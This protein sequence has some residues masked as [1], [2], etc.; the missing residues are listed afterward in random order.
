M[1]LYQRGKISSASSIKQPIKQLISLHYG[2]KAGV[3]GFDSFNFSFSFTGEAA[4]PEK[5]LQ[6]SF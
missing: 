4:S 2:G 3:Y 5:Q 6:K 1:K